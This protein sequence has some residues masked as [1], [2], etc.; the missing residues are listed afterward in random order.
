M[1]AHLAVNRFNEMHTGEHTAFRL[2]RLPPLQ[3]LLS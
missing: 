2:E 3:G 1:R